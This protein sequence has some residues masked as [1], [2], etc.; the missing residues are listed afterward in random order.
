ME[1]IIF[2][3]IEIPKVN[4]SE[5][6]QTEQNLVYSV[7]KDQT[8]VTWLG[9]STPSFVSDIITAEGPFNEDQLHGILENYKWLIFV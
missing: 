5:V 6:I 2:S 1:S 4:F 3:V 8:Y 7:N 9:E